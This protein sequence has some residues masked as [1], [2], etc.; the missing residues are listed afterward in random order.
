MITFNN[1]PVNIRVPGTYI[2]IDNTKAFRGLTGIPAKVLV[3]GQ[4][5]ASGTADALTP[6]PI[7]SV[8]Q[9]EQLF[10]KASQLAHMLAAF[11]E[12]DDFIEVWAI[13]QADNGAG[14]AA[15]G[16]L[17]ISGPSTAAGTIALLI[18]G[19]L[20]QVAV[21]S[22]DASTAIA[23]AVADAINA[24][25]DLAVTAVV[26]GVNTSKVN[27][28]ARHKGECGNTID[29][30]VNY[31]IDQSLPAG[32]GVAV[33]AMS[34]GT[35]NPDVTAALA[36][37]GDI[38][39]TD[40]VMSYTDN[41]NIAAMETE[42]ADRFG[43]LEQRDGYCYMTVSDTHGNLVTKGNARNSPFSMILGGKKLPTPPY[44]IAAVLAAVAASAL[45]IDPARPVQTLALPGVL[46]PAIADRFTMAERAVLLNNGIATFTVDQDGTVRIERLITTYQKNGFGA[47]DPS[48]LD[49]ETLKTLTYLR[50][51]LRTFIA[52]RYPRYKLADDGTAFARGQNVVT[53]SVIGDAI[54]A[55]FRQWEEAGLVENIEQFKKDLIVERNATDVNRVD[56]LL[57]PDIINQLR[58]FAG[59]VEFRL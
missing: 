44:E 46:A 56:A 33:T 8:D 22:G 54:I 10:G 20:T 57:P 19:R 27:I 3:I 23:T 6:Y 12:G 37:T 58:V 17:T 5:L 51:D 59:K 32:V 24:N 28:T 21:A 16:S 47:A 50:Y 25:D 7:T 1:I 13:A 52:L 31:Q 35:G 38:W 49:I 40:L 2:E 48:F 53:P 36:A 41:T 30:R 18:G 26:D 42:L 15:G 39:Y 29:I 45:Q 4:K 11:K 55:R 34:A 43:P 9:A 14:A